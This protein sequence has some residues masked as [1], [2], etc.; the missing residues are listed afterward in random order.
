MAGQT[1]HDLFEDSGPII[2]IR[3]PFDG[4][5]GGFQDDFPRHVV[6]RKLLASPVMLPPRHHDTTLVVGEPEVAGRG[7]EVS[8]F[9]HFLWCEVQSTAEPFGQ[10]TPSL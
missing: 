3:G 10:N 6:I 4:G 2:G 9:L 5:L 1:T 8:E 7:A